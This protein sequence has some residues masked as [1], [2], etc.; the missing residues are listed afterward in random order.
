MSDPHP[1]EDLLRPTLADTE[2]PVALYSLQA[3]CL[4]A[5]FGGPFAAVGFWGLNAHRV[6][7]IRQELPWMLAFAA[8]TFAVLAALELWL[9]SAEGRPM[10]FTERVLV[11]LYALGIVGVAWLRWRARYR[12]MQITGLDSPNGTVPSI[13]C[14]VVGVALYVFAAE[15]IHGRVH[16]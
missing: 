5:F 8:L 15:W 1:A 2:S 7:R 3:F 9:P 10:S 14:I 16:A 12:A 4:T 11:R 13:A 6:G